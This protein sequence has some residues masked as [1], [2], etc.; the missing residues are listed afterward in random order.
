MSD[1]VDLESG[2]NVCL[3]SMITPA[4]YDS[5]VSDKHTMYKNISKQSLDQT[6]PCEKTP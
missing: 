2:R 1:I 3:M 4:I 6:Q 5:V